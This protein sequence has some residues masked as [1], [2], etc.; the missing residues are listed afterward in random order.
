MPQLWQAFDHVVFLT[1]KADSDR[2]YDKHMAEHLGF[3]NW[4][5]IP[6][7]T[8]PERFTDNLPDFR[9]VY[10]TGDGPL[11]LSLANYSPLK[12]QEMALRAFLRAGRREATLVFIGSDLNEYSRG[13]ERI[14]QSCRNPAGRVLFLAK[15]GKPLECAA[16]RAASVF[17]YSSRTEA[18][19]LVL[20]DA[21]ASATPFISTDV[22]CVGELAGGVVVRCE[23][24]MARAINQL[25]DDPEKRRFLGA[26]GQAACKETYNWPKVIDA[27]ENLLH[28]LVEK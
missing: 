5:V 7:G 14:Y 9:A 15:P 11:I 17:L 27:Y 24:E 13:L 12:N 1:E 20:L 16:Y 21:M 4:S 8:Y 10:D 3:T 2:F 23:A 26:Q 28:Q 22:G 18:Q 6:N 19:P 25:L